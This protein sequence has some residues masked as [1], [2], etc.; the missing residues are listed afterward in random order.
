[1]STPLLQLHGIT[2]IFPGVRALENV[3][4]DL[5]PGKVTALVGENGAG[6]STLVKV[7]TGIYQPEEGEI[8]YKA[9]PIQLPNPEAAHKVGITAI[10]QETVL[11]DELSVTENIF[12]GQYLYTGFFK[13]LDWPEMHRRAQAILTRLEV[14]I[15][16][17]ATLKTLSIAQRHM[18]AIA[19][20]LSFEA[21]VVILDE[22]TAALSQHEILE[23][24]QIVERLKQEGKAILFISHK[25][26]E[27]F[28]LADHYTILRD[29]AFVSSGDIH[30]ISEERMVAMMVGRAITQTFPKVACEKG[31]TV[32]EVKDLCHPTEFAH[33]DFTLRKGEILGFYGLVGA[34]RTELMQALSGVSRP[35]HGEIRLNGRAIHFHQP[36]DAIRAGIVCVPEERQKQGAIIE[37][38]IAENISL[39][40]LS[41]LNPRGVLNAA[42]EWQLADSY[43]KRLQV[44]AF[45]WRQAVETLSGGN[46]QKVV[47]GKWLATHPE[48]I[49]LDEPTKGIDIGSKAAVHQFMSELVAQGLAVIM[50]SSELPEVMGMADRII[51]MHEGLMVAQYRAGEATAEAIVSAAS[52]IGKEAA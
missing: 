1:M 25:F 7:M 29:G 49:I 13:K 28:E 40:Q 20:A 11:F 3:Q 27:I 4:L 14:Q 35:S 26:D 21:Q 32:L 16:P 52:G 44:K 2:K 33:I 18:V 34:G 17:R 31:E 42:R 50:V 8:L 30:E 23:F 48:V 37:M 46:Q 47:I 12:V 41:K 24:Y 22:P 15:D 38:S 5:W 39:P 51:V 6:K 10:H 43:A 19:R 36:A 45:S 9:I